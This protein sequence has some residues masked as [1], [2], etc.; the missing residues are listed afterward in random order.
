MNS[1]IMHKIQIPHFLINRDRWPKII[2]MSGVANA[3]SSISHGLESIIVGIF[4]TVESRGI[5]LRMG[6]WMKVIVTHVDIVFNVSSF[7]LFVL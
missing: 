2:K 5:L 4:H 3:S 1:R 6:A 7:A